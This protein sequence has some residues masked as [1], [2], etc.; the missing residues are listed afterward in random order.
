MQ[1]FDFS[2]PLSRYCLNLFGM[3]WF[4]IFIPHLISFSFSVVP[5]SHLSFSQCSVVAV[6]ASVVTRFVS[7]SGLL[8]PVLSLATPP[9]LSSPLAFSLSPLTFWAVFSACAAVISVSA[10]FP[11]FLGS[12]AI[13]V[14]AVVVFSACVDLLL[15]VAVSLLLLLL[16]SAAVSVVLLY[17]LLYSVLLRS[18]LVL[19]FLLNDLCCGAARC[20]E[21]SGAVAWHRLSFGSRPQWGERRGAERCLERCLEWSGVERCLE[22]S[23]LLCCW[24]WFCWVDILIVCVACVVWPGRQHVLLFFLEPPDHWGARN[25]GPVFF[26]SCYDGVV[27]Y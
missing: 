19:H 20:S 10:V 4:L 18:V 16:L 2:Q 24:S 6:C 22:R 21:R 14:V 7:I 8:F 25:E 15:S 17:F 27:H 9:L 13:S 3:L 23:E 1:R 26:L 12:V 5:E 11:V